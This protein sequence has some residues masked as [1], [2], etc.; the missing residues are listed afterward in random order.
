MAEIDEGCLLVNYFG[1]GSYVRWAHE[2]ILHV[3]DLDS[4]N[5]DSRLPVVFVMSQDQD[6]AQTVTVSGRA[7]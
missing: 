5:N 3:G 4:L 6:F 1:H 2:S 7:S